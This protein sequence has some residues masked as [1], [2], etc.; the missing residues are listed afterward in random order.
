MLRTPGIVI[1]C[2]DFEEEIPA[3]VQFCDELPILLHADHRSGDIATI[4]GIEDRQRIIP[5]AVIA[6]C[7][8]PAL[9]DRALGF[10]LEHLGADNTQR[11]QHNPQVDDVSAIAPAVPSCQAPQSQRQVF[12]RPVMPGQ[13]AAPEFIECD[14]PN[15]GAQPE[16]Q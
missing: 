16:T 1:G 2:C 9:R 12:T 3:W 15:K 14:C 13:R 4:W 6:Q 10:G 5:H 8:R 7:D 11:H